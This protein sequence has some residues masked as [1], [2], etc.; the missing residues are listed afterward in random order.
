MQIN[1]VEV[2]KDENKNNGFK[3]IKEKLESISK[4]LRK[5]LAAKSMIAITTIFLMTANCNN[6]DEQK[7]WIPQGYE[8]ECGLSTIKDPTCDEKMMHYICSNPDYKEY[9]LYVEGE[10]IGERNRIEVNGDYYYLTGIYTR[11]ENRSRDKTSERKYCQSFLTSNDPNFYTNPGEIIIVPGIYTRRPPWNTSIN[12]QQGQ[13]LVVACEYAT[14]GC[15]EKETVDNGGSKMT[16]LK[17]EG[18]ALRIKIIDALEY[19]KLIGNNC[20]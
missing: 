8:L 19:K 6:E 13:L 15:T 7:S 16:D 2:K 1:K 10:E 14:K 12:G 9:K 11:M 17:C 3:K 20:Q 5:N 4:G 18:A